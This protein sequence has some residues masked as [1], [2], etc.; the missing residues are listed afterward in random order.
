MKA[1]ALKLVLRSW[2]RNK[3]FSVISIVSLAIGIACTN[4]LAAFVIY[5][6]NIEAGNPDKDRIV[7]MAQD[8][9]M[10]SGETVSYVAG[11]IPVQLKEKYT[12]VEDYLRFNAIGCSSVTIGNKQ[13][14]PITIATTDTAFPRFFR[15]KVL[16]GDLHD[17]LSAPD[18]AALSESCARKLFGDVNP[19]GKIVQ[20]D[21]TDG[22][23]RYNDETTEP[24]RSFQIAAVLKEYPQSYLTFDML[25]GNG[26]DFYGG[27]TLLK[28]SAS[29]DKKEF[30]KKIKADGVPTLQQ[31]KGSYHFYTLQDSYF[32]R[33]TQETIPYITRSQ[34]PL[35]LVGMISA[36]LILLIACFNY[37]NLSFSRIL[38]QIR[39]VHTQKLMGAT[40]A[41]INYQLFLDTFLTV[42]IAFLLSLMIAHDLIPLFNRIMSGRITTGFFLDRQVLPFICGLI[43]ILSVIPAWYMSRKVSALTDSNYRLF[44]TGNKKRKIVT[45]LSIAQY[46][47]SIGLIIGTLTIH[48]QLG[49]IRKKGECYRNLIEIGNW[50]SRN[51]DVSTFATELKNKPEIVSVTRAGGSILNAWLRQIIIENKDGSE[52]YY[53]MIQYMGEENLLQTL[54]LQILRGV[55]P[56]EAIRKY[57]RP[58]YINQRYADILVPAGEDPIGHPVNQ[59][60][61]SFNDGPAGNPEQA[62][63]ICGIVSDLYINSIEEEAM[64]SLVYLNNSS[65]GNFQMLYIKLNEKLKTEGMEAIRTVWEKVNPSEY[66]TYEDV[67]AV[68][69]QRNRKTTDMA[70]LLL[71]YSVI[72]IF[73][74]CFG[75]FGMALY[76]TEQRTKE[77]GIRKVN[78]ASTRSIMFLL[79]RQFIKWIA[80]AF[81]IAVPLTWLLLNRWLESFA[82]RV[83]VSPLYFLLGGI[84]VLAITLLTVG[85]HT[86]RAASGNPVRSLRSE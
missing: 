80:V 81:V 74:T 43:L 9:P 58:V 78:G 41:E 68:F 17:A 72:S 66:F 42:G 30:A 33:Y 25:T 32:Q 46:V 36:L 45:A 62:C 22:G 14:E 76:A 27:I 2:W 51:P 54:G 79:I 53:S 85:W 56:Q 55:T 28:V 60:D 49:L 48:A 8:S 69:M 18:K 83:S 11:D 24:S 70:N 15:Y 40:H 34:R 38:Q 64:P 75:L 67:Y 29:F 21:L 12:E 1:V 23:M 63:T 52:T 16:Y 37:I 82:N 19:V 13:Y 10:K 5:E 73:L 47:I 26:Q 44:F 3:T 31:E 84:I 86:Y 65:A 59:Y 20:I 57:D 6:F 39:I 61:K 35:L 4:L 7:Y 77:I 71:M 50:R